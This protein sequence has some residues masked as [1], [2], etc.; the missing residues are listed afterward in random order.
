[1]LLV[2]SIRHPERCSDV[3]KRIKQNKRVIPV[4]A[5]LVLVQITSCCRLLLSA[6]TGWDVQWGAPVLAAAFG[7]L[8]GSVSSGSM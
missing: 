4:R 6:T 2:A 3:R 7:L 5:K 1:M 8:T